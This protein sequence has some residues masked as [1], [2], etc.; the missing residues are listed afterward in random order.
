MILAPFRDS[1]CNETGNYSGKSR[2]IMPLC[3]APN[4]AFLSGAINGL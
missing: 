1:K 2:T 3:N 4:W